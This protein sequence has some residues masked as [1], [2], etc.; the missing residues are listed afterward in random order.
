MGSKSSVKA[1]KN[2]WVSETGF[3]GGRGQVCEPKVEKGGQ[4]LTCLA[5]SIP[6]HLL[7]VAITMLPLG[8]STENKCSLEQ[9]LA[10]HEF[11][12]WAAP[13]PSH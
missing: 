6:R 2:E 8:C 10:I 7:F 9:S 5:S 4:S 11:K 1:A 13:G 12:E 3:K